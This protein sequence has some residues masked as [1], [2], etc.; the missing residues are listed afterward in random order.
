MKF[1][2]CNQN[3]WTRVALIA[4]AALLFM[5]TIPASASLGGDV[6]SV[7]SDQAHMKATVRVS[8]DIGYNV[9]EMKAAGG[10]AVREYVSN[11]GQVFGVAWD[12]PFRPNLQQV[13]GNYY[14]QF[15]NAAK[16]KRGGHNAPLVIN[17]RGLVVQMSGHQRHFVG[18]AYV[19]QM[20]PQGVQAA[21]IK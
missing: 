19:P 14:N 17:E 21:D 20:L 5:M 7:Q 8:G 15:L 9:H 18:R 10:T 11:T 12:G 2:K 4:A 16:N 3:L 6:A 1:M 13:L